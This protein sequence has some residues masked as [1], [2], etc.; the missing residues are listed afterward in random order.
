VPSLQLK[1]RIF[2]FSE[3]EGSK[4]LC[5]SSLKRKGVDALKVYVQ[6]PI[7]LPTQTSEKGKV[8]PLGERCK[9]ALV[10]KSRPGHTKGERKLAPR[11]EGK[12]LPSEAKEQGLW[13]KWTPASRGR[14]RCED[15]TR[16]RGGREVRGDPSPMPQM[17]KNVLHSSLQKAIKRFF[18]GNLERGSRLTLESA[19]TESTRERTPGGC[20]PSRKARG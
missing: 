7:S 4:N 6:A 19:A 8:T 18:S 5:L 20:P 15:P 16:E 1:R 10:V 11:D 13:A 17:E 12:P 3:K 9:L 2:S 14:A